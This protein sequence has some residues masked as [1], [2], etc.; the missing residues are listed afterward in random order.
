MLPT[1]Q[2]EEL[3][4]LDKNAHF[5]GKIHENSLLKCSMLTFGWYQILVTSQM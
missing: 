5:Y 4:T 3:V 1:I 2:I